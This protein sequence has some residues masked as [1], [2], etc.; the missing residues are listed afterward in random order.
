PEVLP[1]SEE[2]FATAWREETEELLLARLRVG[3][4]V[5]IPLYLA[6]SLLDWFTARAH[7][8]PFLLIRI[9]VTGTVGLL[10]WWQQ[11]P[12]ARR[13]LL[14][15]SFAQI[16]LGSAGISAMTWMLG[17]FASPYFYGNMLVLFLLGLFIP[18]PVRL[19]A[20]LG[21]AAM[22]VYVVPN[23]VLHGF[24]AQALLPI[25]F[26]AGTIVLTC[27]ATS[28]AE[29]SR[30]RDLHQRLQLAKAN[31]AVIEAD[32]MKTKFFSNV[33]HELR[34]PLMLILGPL[35]SLLRGEAEGDPTMLLR[36][37]NSN[38][39]RLLRQVN[40]ILNF[41]RA[42]DGRL[43]VNWSHGNVGQ[44]IRQYLEGTYPYA[45][46]RNIELVVEGIDDL[47]DNYFD[48]EHVETAT[49]NLISNALKFTPDGGRI[50][51]RGGHDEE[52]LWWEVEDTGCGIPEDQLDKVF[53]RFHQ[54][55]GGRSGKIQGTGLGL[56]LSKEMMRLHHGDITVRSVYGEGTTFRI[57]LPIAP[58]PE[59]EAGVAEGPASA[60]AGGASGS[61]RPAKDVRRSSD[62]STQLADLNEASLEDEGLG[63]IRGPEGA[64]LLLLVEDNPDV[65][66]WVASELRQNY[67][68]VTAEDG[69]AGVEAARKHR[70]DLIISDV[71]MPNLDGFGLVKELRADKTFA[72]TPILLLT[73]RTGSD[74]VVE[75]LGLGA[76]D[77]VNKPFRKAELEA[78]I[79][80]HL[81]AAKAEHALDE[82]ESR[83]LRIGQMTST[84]AHDLRG[85][86]TSILGRIDLVR[87]FAET[88]GELAEIED[89]LASV[90]RVVFRVTAMAEE[91]MEYA[92]GGSV[93][94]DRRPTEV[95]EFVDGVAA[96]LGG[97]LADA[98]VDLVVEHE[99]DGP[100]PA[101]L[102]PMR[103]QR[104]LENLINN[105]RDAL[106]G[107]EEAED[108]RIWLQTRRDQGA[109]LIR[110]ADNG[111][112]IPE[113]LA[114]TLF[115]PFATAGKANGT[116]LGLAIVRNLVE[117][118]DGTIEVDRRPPE[119]GAAF[120]L[121]LPLAAEQ[122]SAGEGL[123]RPSPE[124]TTTG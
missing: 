18:W 38:A 32:K 108:K 113:E 4:G 61:N 79:Q 50:T 27:W 28:A 10:L 111:P 88:R 92:R 89:D 66:S 123:E 60:E 97:P 106:N 120:L 109:V 73:A 21:T 102:D 33:S 63:E 58:P 30:R 12:A 62:L 35:D 84:I 39:H 107:Q 34:T 75:G 9:V 86:L 56:S 87:L 22:A 19:T 5:G 94:L 72:A 54:V 83:L 122:E 42:I 11:R 93:N 78:R 14:A 100:L 103:M 44:V 15:T 59:A 116:G 119:G 80:A 110:V 3:L 20:G 124:P 8:L 7:W 6:F 31:E 104:V 115:Q 90:E 57:T 37:M 105:A 41:S 118:H 1:I 29:Q 82:R 55:D 36:A 95:R 25:F 71:M 67:R 91:L 24:D 46:Q 121:Q 76:S 96:D 74:A 13:H 48:V 99:G 81:R 65:R 17:G 114:E 16:L 40:Q 23:A 101:S 69:R 85:P 64:P 112:G 26:L 45:K 52:N 51:V 117:A 49:A 77:Y 43:Q 47:P 98:G 2:E 70:P 53:E 68:V